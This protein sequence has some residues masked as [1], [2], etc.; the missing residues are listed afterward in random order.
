MKNFR[1]KGFTLVELLIVIV[2]IGVL[3]AMMMFS[4]TEAVS[5]ARAAEVISNMN[6]MKKAALEYYADYRMKIAADPSGNTPLLDDKGSENVS[7]RYRV[8]QYLKNGD[9]KFAKELVKQGYQYESS[10]GQDVGRRHT[11]WYVEYTVKDENIKKRLIG[12]AQSSGLLSTKNDGDTPDS[13]YAGEEKVYM[14]IR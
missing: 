6:M 12:R 11:K 8:V 2:V 14:R 13:V 5:S 7:S 1:C 9:L 10:E 3:A 4:S